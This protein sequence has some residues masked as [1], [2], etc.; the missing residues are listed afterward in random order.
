M[1]PSPQESDS[2]AP[3][4]GRSTTLPATG[5]P[6]Q[7][8]TGGSTS[9]F[10]TRTRISWKEFIE[11]SQLH[12]PELPEMPSRIDCTGPMTE[13]FDFPQGKTLHEE[14]QQ[15]RAQYLYDFL[16]EMGAMVEEASNQY[17]VS[18][19]MW[20]RATDIPSVAGELINVIHQDA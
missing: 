4:P 3:L 16:K 18:K 5:H 15:Q 11:K 12:M 19:N 7:Q 14:L 9:E 13:E 8:L 1:E 17:S 20:D 2:G 6:I 10:G